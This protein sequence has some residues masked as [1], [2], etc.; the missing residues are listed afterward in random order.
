MAQRVGRGIALLFHDRGTR[1]E[2][3]V[4]STPRPHFTPGK[5]PVPISQEAGW[6]P[7]S[8]WM[9][10]KSRPHWDSIQIQMS[11]KVNK[12]CKEISQ[13]IWCRIW[14]NKNKITLYSQHRINHLT[15][16]L[17][18]QCI[19]QQ[20]Y[21]LTYLLTHSMEHSPSWEANRLS[22]SQKNSLHYIEPEG[23]LV[24]SQVPTSCPYPEPARS[25]PHP[26]FWRSILIL[27]SHLRLAL[28]CG[29]CWGNLKERVPSGFPTKTLYT[30]LLS[31][32]CATC[33]AH[34]NSPP[35]DQDIKWLPISI[36]QQTQTLNGCPSQFSNNRPRH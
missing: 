20:T 16:E 17:N 24:Q 2:W 35:T 14:S 1:R 30:P 12:E 18:V 19:F 5:D 36:L 31:P 25:S 7:G 26:T 32:I 28:P 27:S 33:P 4:R 29:F 8:L 13:K 10:G 34:L 11:I 21:W 23:S 15:S 9:G 3:V 6:V 22:T